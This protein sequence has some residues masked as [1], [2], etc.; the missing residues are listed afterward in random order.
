MEKVTWDMHSM[1][2]DW[3]NEAADCVPCEYEANN[4]LSMNSA[5]HSSVYPEL[6][7]RLPQRDPS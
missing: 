3:E 5:W 1:K 4:S 2:G 6:Q 7:L